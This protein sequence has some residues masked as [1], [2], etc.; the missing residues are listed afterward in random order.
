[1]LFPLN[2]GYVVGELGRGGAELQLLQLCEGLI[3][4]GHHVRVRTYGGTAVLDE[5]FRSVGVD[6][7]TVRATTRS[8]KVQV[9]RSWMREVDLDVV[10]GILRSASTVAL[11]ARGRSSRPTL[12]ASD[13][14]EAAY[15]R[16]SLQLMASLVLFGRANAVVTEVDIN[17]RSLESKAPWLRGKTHLIRNG[18]DSERFVPATPAADRDDSVFVFCC[19][20]TLSD[21]KNPGRVVDAVEELTRRGHTGFMVDWYG[22]DSLEEARN[23]GPQ[24]RETVQA[25]GLSPHIVFHGDVADIE[26]AYQRSD[27]L[28]HASV[29]EGFPNAVAEGM[30]CGLPIVVS[31]VSDLPH[32]VKEARNGFVFDETDPR[33][34]ADAME[35]LMQLPRR[36]RF[37]MG[38]RSRALAVRW[39]DR[40][41]FF[42]DVEQLYLSLVPVGDGRRPAA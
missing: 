12:I 28:V 24:V 9:I 19:V 35:R 14:S 20:G 33:S 26:R 36:E 40:E 41:R 7:S 16:W 2:I 38:V 23:V 27:A 10:H 32:V 5:H 37:E 1:M 31:R 21:V 42:D 4:R 6:V 17:K 11:L 30:A 3:N 25:H 22:R 39:F 8:H 34:I 15:E 18:L 13:Y 29:R